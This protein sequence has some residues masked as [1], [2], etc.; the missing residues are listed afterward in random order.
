MAASVSSRKRGRPR[1]FTQPSQV[2]ALTLPD[3]VVRGLRRVHPD[4][5]WAIVTVFAK[6]PPAPDGT[7]RPDAELVTVAGRQSLIVVKRKAFTHLPGVRV[8]PLDGYRA[9]LALEPGKGMA[10]LELAVIDRLADGSIKPT[11]RQVL[12]DFQAQLRRWRYNRELRF[13]S[14]SIIVVERLERRRQYRTAA[15]DSP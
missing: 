8:I 15:T 12:G 10:D 1:K 4:L 11:E 6:S 13:K 7:P 2:V 5:A 3:D 9:F 14:Q